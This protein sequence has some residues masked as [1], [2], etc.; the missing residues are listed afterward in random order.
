[1]KR[2]IIIWIVLLAAAVLISGATI[3]ALAAPGT[4]TDP[5][6]TLSYLTNIFKPQVMADVDKIGQE[7]TQKIDEQIGEIEARLE[8]SQGSASITPGAADKFTVVSLSRGQSLTCSV[9][10]EIMLRIGTATG[11]GSEPALV[12]YTDGETLSSGTALKANHMYLVTIEGNG[13]KATADLVR[14]LVRGG[15]K[16]T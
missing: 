9:G 16:V 3:L 8:S 10:A 12:D 14:V 7:M 13:V 1:M 5:F 15:Y 11:S 4:Q 2:K 6:I